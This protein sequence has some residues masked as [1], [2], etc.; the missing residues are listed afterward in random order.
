MQ[1]RSSVVPSSVG[2]SGSGFGSG[3]GSRVRSGVQVRASVQGSGLEFRFGLQL[4]GSGP[5]FGQEFRFG[6]RFRVRV[7]APSSVLSSG[8][9]FGS[10][11]CGVRNVGLGVLVQGPRL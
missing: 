8:S 6:V 9:E 4:M 10:G 5:E 2:N 3:F 11:F 1:V 7:G